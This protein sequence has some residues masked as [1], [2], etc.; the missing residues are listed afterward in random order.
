MKK[1]KLVVFKI[2]LLLFMGTY[3]SADTWVIDLNYGSKIINNIPEKLNVKIKNI[4]KE[5]QKFKSKDLIFTIYPSNQEMIY[6][7]I[8]KIKNQTNVSPGDTTEFSVLFNEFYFVNT[9][10]KSLELKNVIGLL[11]KLKWSMKTCIPDYDKPK[12]LSIPLTYSNLIEFS[13]N[14]P[15]KYDL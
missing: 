15:K 14:V 4:S 2:I 13:N 12:T 9:G 5:N 8:N 1:I 6:G 10:S 11:K 3:V 7:K